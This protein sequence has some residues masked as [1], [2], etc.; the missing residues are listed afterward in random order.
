MLIVAA[1]EYIDSAV[2]TRES[3]STSARPYAVS[4]CASV[5]TSFVTF[6]LFPI[7]AVALQSDACNVLFS[8][9]YKIYGQPGLYKRKAQK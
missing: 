3:V 9:L 5:P 6:N 8:D 7:M 4:S 2:F 1:C